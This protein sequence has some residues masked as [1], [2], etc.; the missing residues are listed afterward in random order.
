MKIKDSLIDKCYKLLGEE[1]L[2]WFKHLKGLTG[3]CSPVLKLNVKRKGIPVHPVHF[4]EGM[5][6]R[7][8]MR[9]EPECKGWN[10]FDFDNNWTKLIELTINK[11]LTKLQSHE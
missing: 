10:D 3:T 11:H 2:R 4:R 9:S 1:N 8:F 6:I 5:Q 7:N